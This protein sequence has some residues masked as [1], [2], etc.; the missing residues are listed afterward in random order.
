M[1]R[2]SSRL[3]GLA[4][5][6]TISTAM[7]MQEQ[8]LIIQNEAWGYGLGGG[9][10]DIKVS[11]NNSNEEIQIPGG[12][13]RILGDLNNINQIEIRRSGKMTSWIPSFVGVSTITSQQLNELKRQANENMGK[14]LTLVIGA[15]STGYGLYTYYWGN[16]IQQEGRKPTATKHDPW[17]IFPQAKAA[18]E[19]LNINFFNDSESRS[20]LIA[21]AKLVLGFDVKDN[22]DKEAVKKRYRQLS[23]R[24]HPDK[25]Q[26]L[27]ASMIS[28]K[29]ADEAYAIVVRANKILG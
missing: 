1:K 18:K 6:F 17:S 25:A 14:N 19:K 10:Y 8:K 5:F 9:Y 22:P 15:T 7:A 24:F 23:L 21:V 12:E 2:Y 11:I 29:F 16:P 28:D 26:D 4:L 13:M 20:K 27:T 3:A